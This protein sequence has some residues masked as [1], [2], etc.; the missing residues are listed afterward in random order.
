MREKMSSWKRAVKELVPDATAACER[1]A[2]NI[3]YIKDGFEFDESRYFTAKM[4]VLNS[5]IAAGKDITKAALDVKTEF[6]TMVN[7]VAI[8]RNM[9]NKAM[10]AE[11][12]AHVNAYASLAQGGVAAMSALIGA[13]KGHAET[14]MLDIAVLKEKLAQAETFTIKSLE[15]NGVIKDNVVKVGEKRIK[16]MLRD[17]VVQAQSILMDTLIPSDD[18]SVIGNIN[19][20][21]DFKLV[22]HQGNYSLSDVSVSLKKKE[23]IGIK[24]PKYMNLSE[25]TVTS[26]NATAL[27][28]QYSLNGIA[29]K[30]APT[31]IVDNV[32]KTQSTLSAAYV[33]IVNKMN[34]NIHLQMKQLLVKP[35]YALG[36]LSAT[37]DLRT[38]QGTMENTILFQCGCNDRKLCSYRS[39]ARNTSV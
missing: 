6:E 21:N 29:W 25:I 39:W 13:E 37:T 24:L 17:V 18:G 30:V 7:D 26:A 20:L 36:V 35:I 22:F 3:A 15:N 12:E 16:T 31:V 5:A 1:F 4:D 34:R 10:V 19:G 8:L 14:T 11:I 33:R 9:D 38:Y 27:E 28:L 23:T 32:M 2:D